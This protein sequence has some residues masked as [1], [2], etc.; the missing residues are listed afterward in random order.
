MKFQL[1]NQISEIK[2]MHDKNKFSLSIFVFH[3]SF[4]G[5]YYCYM[6]ILLCR[7][8]QCLDRGDLNTIP[9]TQLESFS[10]VWPL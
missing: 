3:K 7:I 1:N 4:L 8:S 6:K 2:D 5:E 10:I 9:T